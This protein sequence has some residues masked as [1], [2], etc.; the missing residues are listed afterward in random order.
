[1]TIYNIPGANPM[2]NSA[3]P[4]T[5]IQLYLVGQNESAQANS[6]SERGVSHT[7]VLLHRKLVRLYVAA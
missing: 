3:I 7:L 5:A 4:R 2:T 1:M 6:L